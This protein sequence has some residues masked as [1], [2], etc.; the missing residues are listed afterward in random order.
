[1]K[2]IQ[3]LKENIEKAR[4]EFEENKM[5]QRENIKKQ[6]EKDFADQNKKDQIDSETSQ[7]KSEGIQVENG[8]LIDPGNLTEEQKKKIETESGLSF[9]KPQNNHISL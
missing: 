9:D 7:L 3:N 1:M 4:K 2:E 6:I 5:I 8:K